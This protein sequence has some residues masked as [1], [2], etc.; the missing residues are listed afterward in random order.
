MGRLR[1]IGWAAIAL[2]SLNFLRL[3]PLDWPG[4]AASCWCGW[5]I[6]RRRPSFLLATAIAGGI[7]VADSLLSLVLL[8]PLLL[9]EYGSSREGWERS[10]V[11][12][13]APL[14]LHDGVQACFWSWAAA[15]ALRNHDALGV[16]GAYAVHARD[17]MIGAFF[18]SAWISFVI[19]LWAKTLIF[20][21]V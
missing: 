16:R 9:R 17:T 8:G 2:G 14:L 3:F 11:P 7:V 6:L 1:V 15:S 18:V 12:F 5:A 20:R 10:A 13:L 21:L 4:I 19:Q